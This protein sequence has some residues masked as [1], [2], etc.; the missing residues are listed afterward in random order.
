MTSTVLS[1]GSFLLLLPLRSAFA[2]GGP[3][4]PVIGSSAQYRSTDRRSAPPNLHPGIGSLRQGNPYGAPI[5]RFGFIPMPLQPRGAPPCPMSPYATF[6]NMPQQE[7]LHELV[8]E[9]RKNGA[10]ESTMREYMNRYV[11]EILSPEKFAQFE[12]ANVQFEAMRRGKRSY[13][14]GDLLKDDPYSKEQIHIRK[15]RKA[16]KERK[17]KKDFPGKS[18]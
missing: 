3:N 10:S 1:I 5:Q 8:T 9:A 7:A 6:L 13:R 12:Q 15:P 17:M 16:L 18:W 11:R 14:I 4:L 2:P